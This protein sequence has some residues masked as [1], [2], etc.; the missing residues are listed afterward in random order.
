MGPQQEYP[1]ERDGSY[2]N[3]SAETRAEK[4]TDCLSSPKTASQLRENRAVQKGPSYTGIWC[5]QG[6]EYGL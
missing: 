6:H 3:D 1:T 5:E 2:D 4:Q